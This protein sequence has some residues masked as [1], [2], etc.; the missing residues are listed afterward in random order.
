M[1]A[2][3]RADPPPGGTLSCIEP[4]VPPPA[5]AAAGRNADRQDDR[6]HHRIPM[7]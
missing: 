2:R 1:I 6:G 5:R 3:F 7:R 4:L